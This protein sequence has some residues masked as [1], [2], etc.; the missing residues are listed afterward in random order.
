[1][2]NVKELRWEDNGQHGQGNLPILPY[3]GDQNQRALGTQM[4]RKIRRLIITT[5]LAIL[6]GMFLL[7]LIWGLWP[8]PTHGTGSMRHARKWKDKLAECNSLDDVRKKFNCVDRRDYTGGSYSYV[9]DP[10]TYREGNTWAFLIDLPNGD[11]LAMAYASS[12]GWKGG[13]TVVTRDSTGRI[14]SFFGH[15]CGRPPAFGETL[16]ELY[17]NFNDRYW[18]EVPLAE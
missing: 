12:H 8:F 3:S 7:I 6:V 4:S 5:V 15:V 9:R 14:R 10:N 17:S 11:W 2:L 1:M 16:E 18:K 13:G